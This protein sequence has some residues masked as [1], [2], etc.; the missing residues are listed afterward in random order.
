MPCARVE[1]RA[2]LLRLDGQEIAE[3][4]DG[5]EAAAEIELLDPRAHRLGIAHVREH[6]RR[7]VNRDDGVAACD[8]LPRDS[9]RAAAEL[10][11]RRRR[12]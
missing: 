3:Q 12:R 4:E 6:L 8:E 7:F 10:E 9:A 2:P 5:V 11:Q 1:E